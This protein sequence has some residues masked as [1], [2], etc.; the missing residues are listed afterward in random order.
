MGINADKN[1][2]KAFREAQ[3]NALKNVETVI[4][5]TL[6]Y[7]GEYAATLAKDRGSYT[8]RTGNLKSSVGYMLAVDGKIII[9]LF[10]GSGAAEGEQ[11]AQEKLNELN[12]K[13]VLIVVA[14]MNYASYVENKD[15]DVLLFTEVMAKA[16]AVELFEQ[17]AA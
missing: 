4:I 13:Y 3:E 7:V 1:W 17:I 2:K 5:N 8:D 16:K 12:H 10:E 9:S 15:Y 6:S 14:G 11:F